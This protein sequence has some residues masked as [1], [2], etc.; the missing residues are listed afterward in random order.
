MKKCINRMIS[1]EC[2]DETCRCGILCENRKFQNHEYAHVYPFPAG[3][4]GWGL[5][6][7]EKINK[8]EFIMQYIGEV[9]GI[10][11][12]IGKKRVKEYSSSACTYLMKTS[13]GEVIDPTYKGNLA[14]FI[15]HSC[16]PNCI[17]Q[18]WNVLG[19]ICIGIFALKD[20]EEND[21]LTFDY[22]FDVYNTP[23]TK[24]L[25]GAKKCKGYLGLRPT[26]ISEDKWIDWLQEMVC[27][28]CRVNNEDDEEKLIL[29][30]S[31]NQ[32]F[33]IY[34]LTPPL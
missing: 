7:G 34:C 18:K 24:C 12:E 30:D 27:E 32:G 22:Q 31:C 3:G 4:K 13:R 1:T 17:T 11:S 20:I 15:N 2:D 16:E 8:G 25:C 28:I 26:N 6:A 23:L 10:N 21:E 5:C 29:C 33:H 9:F 19:E 14:R